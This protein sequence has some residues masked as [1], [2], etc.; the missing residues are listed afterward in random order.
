M[1]YA[2]VVT[3]PART[4]FWQ[5]LAHSCCPAGAFRRNNLAVL[6][7]RNATARAVPD[8]RPQFFVQDRGQ[9]PTHIEGAIVKDAKPNIGRY[10][11]AG[12]TQDSKKMGAIGVK[13]GKGRD[14]AKR[15]AGNHL[16]PALPG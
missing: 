11:G 12:M 15:C 8:F 6:F 2:K 14:N 3:I 5:G 16:G 7:Q 4:R 1:T 13:E 10:P 9:E